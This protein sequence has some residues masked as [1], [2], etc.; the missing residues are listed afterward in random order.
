[1]YALGVQRVNNLKELQKKMDDEVSDWFVNA[2]RLASKVETIFIE[3]PHLC[4]RKTERAIAIT[5][6]R[7][8]SQLY[9]NSICG[10]CCPQNF[11]QTI[12]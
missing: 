2:N 10:P 9:C 8:L 11:I 1:M 6:I 5:E 3:I 4:K 7:L 12:E